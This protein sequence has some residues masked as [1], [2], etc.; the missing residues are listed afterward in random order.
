MVY[1]NTPKSKNHLYHKCVCGEYTAHKSGICKACRTHTCWHCENTF[2]SILKIVI[3]LCPRCSRNKKL[4]SYYTVQ[5]KP[6]PKPEVDAY[7]RFKIGE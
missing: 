6:Y 1:A 2:I 5:R 7:G 3:L 4:L